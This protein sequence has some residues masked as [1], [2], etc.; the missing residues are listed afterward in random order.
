MDTRT[1]LITGITGQDG[2]FL[3]ELLLDK[4][5]MVHGLVRRLSHPTFD[6]IKHIQ[7]RINLIDG[8]LGDYISIVSAVKK[9]EPDEIYN[10][11]AQS[12]VATSWKQAEYTSNITGLGALRVFEAVRQIG[13]CL[14]RQ[15][16]VYHASSSEQF[17]NVPT[18]QNE[19]SQM[20]PR[21][22]YAVSKLFAH[23]MAM[24]YRESYRMFISCGIGFNHS[25]PR[26]GIEFVTRKVSN[27]A[28][29]IKLG[30]SKELRLGNLDSKRDWSDARD[31]VY[32]MYLTLQADK[33]DD[34]ILSSGKSHTIKELVEIAFNR[35]G[36]DWEDYVVIDEKFYRPAEV[37][38]LQGDYSK[39]RKILGWAPKIT[40]KEM[41]EEMVDNDLKI[42]AKEK[43]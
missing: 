27:G 4:G 43:R 40:F 41:V 11:G 32:G 21:S 18:P 38:H 5:Y 33:P 25:G 42:L 19:E 23:R 14:G 3:A 29:K 37:N 24:V 1:A 36:L 22:P 2:S 15:I 9:C 39:A 6:N 20:I 26:R 35:V 30:L 10:L 13:D 8:D 34:Y 7:D 28:A 16:K 12:F 17:G 31:I